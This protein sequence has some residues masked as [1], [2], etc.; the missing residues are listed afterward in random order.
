MPSGADTKWEV[1]R[2]AG[3]SAWR[4]RAAFRRL[5]LPA[6]V[7]A[8]WVYQVFSGAVRSARMADAPAAP[9]GT[10]V[11][12]VGN[13]E[14]GGGGKTPL[15]IYLLERLAGEAP[16]YLSRGYGSPSNR[17]SV[18]T[19]I[20]PEQW[21]GPRTMPDGLRLLNRRA[22]GLAARIGDEGAM[23]LRRLPGVP[24]V[25][26]A[27]KRRALEL[28]LD[29]FSPRIVVLDDAFQSWGLPRHLDIVMVDGD[30]PFADG[31]TLPAGA[32]REPPEALERAD[33]IGVNGADGDGDLERAENLVYSRT[34]SRK[35]VFGV[36]RRLRFVSRPPG[37]EP[38]TCEPC[39][40][41]S[42]LARPD[43]FEAQVA[44]NGLPVAL[45]LRFPDHHSYTRR[46]LEWILSRS[47]RGGAGKIVTTE[48][49]WVKLSD[50]DPPP[51]RFVIA[52]LDLETT[53]IDPV[54]V[55]KKA[56]E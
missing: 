22:P 31:W 4:D 19:M 1:V 32:L 50:L 15:C 51:D 30:R 7:P 36:R 40:V 8:S 37:G 42:A 43:R 39:A 29:V 34:G 5:L 18:A 27:N 35:P 47:D 21:A 10:T 2:A 44:A 41:S 25:F 33:L 52:R 12:S 11:V 28:A 13:L 56:A 45:A 17:G 3:R 23:A 53:G 16:L 38:V 14:A 55:I 24:L 54:D 48:K 49:D 9:D 20:P 6:L 26:C 46:D